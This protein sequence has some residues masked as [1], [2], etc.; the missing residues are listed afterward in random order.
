VT[1]PNAGSF[2]PRQTPLA[3]AATMSTSTPLRTLLSYGARL[4]PLAIFG[5]IGHMHSPEHGTENL[6]VLIEHGADLNYASQRYGT[7]LIY[8]V[9]RNK[10]EKL[11]LLLE[12]GAN[13]DVRGGGRQI[14]AFEVAKELDRTELFDMLDRAR[15]TSAS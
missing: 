10:K 5:A 9:Q 1:N 11:R 4:D 15:T 2:P 7:P 13:P 8:A 12:H 3:A 6:T 14:T